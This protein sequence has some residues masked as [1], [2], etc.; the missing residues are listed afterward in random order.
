[1][2]AEG[3]QLGRF[4]AEGLLELRRGAGLGARILLVLISAPAL[5]AQP[6]LH[7]GE[8]DIVVVAR[9][10]PLAGVQPTELAPT[11][12]QQEFGDAP[13]RGLGAEVSS[14]PGAPDVARDELLEDA[15]RA[16]AYLELDRA[17]RALALV[18]ADVVCASTPVPPEQV[19]EAWFVQALVASERGD[20]DAMD[21]AFR[22]AHRH[23]GDL[24][25]DE[26]IAPRQLPRF[27]AAR[28]DLPPTARLRTLPVAAFHLEGRPAKRGEDGAV[29]LARGRYLL[30]MGETATWVD[31][32]DGA[33]A[34]VVIGPALPASTLDG[35]EAPGRRP[36]MVTVAEAVFGPG[37]PFYLTNRTS[38]WAVDAEHRWTRLGEGSGLPPVAELPRGP[39]VGP[40]ASPRP[41]SAPV[42]QRRGLGPV[43]VTGLA[44][45]GGGAAIAAGSWVWTSS[46]LKAG[47]ADD[48]D[49]VGWEDAHGQY[50]VARAGVYLGYGLTGA[51]VALAGVGIAGR[52]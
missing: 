23:D 47:R 35:V 31:L 3:V 43:A 46:A 10:G 39:L 13:V 38:T 28:E 49:A 45:A 2:F 51:G 44:L 37:V 21:A 36:D 27:E 32:A 9:V 50:E 4:G 8:S 33:D 18:F 41:E 42:E 1:M 5:A 12:L 22:A 29:S 6:V 19:A 17:D 52:W 14:C 24:Q 20:L 26:R 7:D 48:V 40:V 30:R 25:W 11:T 16:L 15:R 34:L